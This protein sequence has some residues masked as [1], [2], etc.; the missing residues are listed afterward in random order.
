MRIRYLKPCTLAYVDW[1]LKRARYNVNVNVGARSKVTGTSTRGAA[2]GR[3][4]YQCNMS[5]GNIYI[6]D[7]MHMGGGQGKALE[8]V[9][10]D[11]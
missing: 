8:L 6:F 11:T 9:D 2:A 10:T 1:A 4:R 5:L 3:H 7:S